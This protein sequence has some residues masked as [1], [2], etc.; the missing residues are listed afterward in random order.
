MWDRKIIK[1]EENGLIEID[2]KVAIMIKLTYKE[3]KI[4]A[5]N[6]FK[7]HKKKI[8]YKLKKNLNFYNWKNIWNENLLLAFSRQLDIVKLKIGKFEDNVKEIIWSKEQ[9]LKKNII[10]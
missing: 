6:R 10:E 1:W 4:T 8:M 9:K 7:N 5:V 3:F 2:A